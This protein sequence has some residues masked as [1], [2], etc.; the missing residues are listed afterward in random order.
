MPFITVALTP[1][2]ILNSFI[3][4]TTS[5]RFCTVRLISIPFIFISSAVLFGAPAIIPALPP[6]KVALASA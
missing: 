6:V 4:P 3:A 2:W 1:V 5:F